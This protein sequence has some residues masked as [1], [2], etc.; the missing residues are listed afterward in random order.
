MKTRTLF[1]VLSALVTAYGCG[2]SSHDDNGGEHGDVHWSYDGEGAPANWADLDEAYAACGAGT[3]QS[4]IDIAGVTPG[5]DAEMSTAYAASPLEIVNNGHTVQVNYTPGSTLTYHGEAYELKQFHFHAGSEHTT[6]GTRHAMEMHLVH[7]TAAG[8]L[9]VVGVFIDAGAENAALASVFA[10]LPAEEGDPMTIAGATVDIGAALPT[11]HASWRY[12]GSLTTPPCTE[13]VSWIVLS[14]PIEASAAQIGSFTAL[15]DH[16]YRPAQS[17]GAREVTGE[18]E[19]HE[20]VHWSYDGEGAPEHWAD[21]EE[22]YAACGSGTEQSP[23]DI[24]ADLVPG[25]DAE[26]STTYASSPLEIV[27]NGH[28]V[29]VNYAAG[30]ALEYHGETYELKQFHFHA[31]SEHTTGGT[32]HAMEMHLV[33]ATAEGKLAVVGVFIDD[34]AENAALAGVFDNLPAE[35]G[36]PMTVDGVTVDIAAALPADHASWRYDGSLTTPPCTEGVSWIVLANPIEASAAQI[37]KF[38]ALFDHNFRPSQDLGDR[39]VAGEVDHGEVHWGYEGEEGPE[40]W[41]DLDPEWAT[42]GTGTEQSP[43]DIAGDVLPGEAADLMMSYNASPIE[44]VNNGHTIQVNYEAGSTLT[45][46]GTTYDLKQFHFHAGSEHTT[47]GDRHAVEMHMVHATADGQLAVVG[48]L[49]DEG[50]END[51]L[52]SV[53]ANLPDVSGE[54]ET[55]DG[56]SV[57]IAA[58]LP[59]SLSSWRYD[60]SLTTPPCSEGVR[61]ILLSTPIEASADQLSGFTTIFDHN[62]RPVQPLNGRT[63]EGD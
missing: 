54:P 40:H 34:G 28:T 29:Q 36:D 26:M 19:V 45:Y 16:N 17:L 63:V 9:A 53:F 42:C 6:G 35:E 27:N 55:V 31:G 47:A 49:I 37:G 7:A 62:Y 52:A 43:I 23:I 10:N 59:G 15:F 61:W 44:V 11:D 32:Q 57:D 48:V 38:T 20:D 25:E 5:Q 2:D 4:P 24:A 12:D 41:G 22:E 51:A 39:E 33:H 1:L 8:K 18:A 21:L 3:E 60:G 46:G 14:N 13:G 56:E 30:S 50:A 58:A